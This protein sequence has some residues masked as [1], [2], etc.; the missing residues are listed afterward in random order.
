MEIFSGTK[1]LSSFPEWFNKE[2][3]NDYIYN[4][5]ALDI[6][7]YQYTEEIMNCINQ[8]SRQY[9]SEKCR[10]DE[11]PE[12]C[13]QRN[14]HKCHVCIGY[15]SF[16]LYIPHDL[17]LEDVIKIGHE[18]EERFGSVYVHVSVMIGNVLIGKEIE[19]SAFNPIEHQCPTNFIIKM[20]NQ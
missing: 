18:L 19:L 20:K 16:S 9:A 7:R 3:L 5:Q 6:L 8:R 15:K 10:H 13:M 17:I 12:I 11:N 2:Y 14:R 4:D 1:K